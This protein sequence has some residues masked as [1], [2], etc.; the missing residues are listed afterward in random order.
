MTVLLIILILLYNYINAT[1][2]TTI[3]CLGSWTIC[4]R[5]KPGPQCMGCIYNP[6]SIDMIFPD[7]YSRI[8][9]QEISTI[10]NNNFYKTY[11]DYY[12]LNNDTQIKINS[13]EQTSWNDICD[14]SQNCYGEPDVFIFSCTESNKNCTYTDNIE[15]CKK[16]RICKYGQYESPTNNG[17]QI[18]VGQLLDGFQI[19]Q[20]IEC[21]YTSFNIKISS[22]IIEHLSISNLGTI[23]VQTPNKITSLTYNFGAW[24]TTQRIINYPCS[25]GDKISTSINIK[26]INVNSMAHMIYMT[27]SNRSVMISQNDDIILI[28]KQDQTLIIMT[29]ITVG[30]ISIS[31]VIIIIFAILSR[32]LYIK[33]YVE[34]ISEPKKIKLRL[35]GNIENIHNI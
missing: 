35:R 4:S 17:G 5:G 31:I 18:S 22:K 2:F 15:L 29:I 28:E 3:H 20:N 23:I 13:I 34:N 7:M 10:D 6:N 21:D 25:S 12:Q 26:L 30:I 14:S 24:S 32:L 16:I 8:F 19:E 33:Y 27:N 9:V 1:M 11:E